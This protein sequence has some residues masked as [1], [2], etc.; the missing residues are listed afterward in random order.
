MGSNLLRG[1]STRAVR[2]PAN[3]ALYWA[4][5]GLVALLFALKLH[6]LFLQNINWDEFVYLAMVHAAARGELSSVLQTGYV[7]VFAWLPHVSNSEVDQVIAARGVM[8][9]LQAATCGFIYLVGRRLFVSATAAFAGVLVYLT[10]SFVVEH[11]TSFRADP[12]AIF[13]L[14][15]ALWLIVR[16]RGGMTEI[17][18]AGIL[19]GLAGMVTIKSAFYVPTL[20][21]AVLCLRGHAGARQRIGE[22]LALGITA[23]ATFLALYLAHRYSLDGATGYSA[24]DMVSR[25]TGKLIMVDE[26]FPRDL[27]IGHSIL[28]DALAWL[29][30]L[31]GFAI[32]IGV[33]LTRGTRRHGI[34]LAGL[35]LPLLTLVF[36]RNAFPYYFVFMLAAPA[37]LVA[38]LVAYAEDRLLAAKR[39]YFRVLVGVLVV[40]LTGGMVERYLNDNVDRTIVQRQVVDTVHRM[41]PEPVPYIDRCSMIASFPKA[42]FFMSTWGLQNYLEIGRPVM[43]DLLLERKPVFLIGNII[44]LI[45][46]LQEDTYSN[47]LL[48]EDLTVLREN[49]LRHWG[50]IWVAG[51]KLDVGA[52]GSE[53]RFEILIPGTYTLDGEAPVVIDGVERAPGDRVELEQ[54]EHTIYSRQAPISV[55][56]RWGVDLYRPDFLPEPEPVFVS[57]S[58]MR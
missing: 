6:L 50:L 48:P 1:P 3:P 58:G 8:F 30:L 39:I 7:H 33:A 31:I 38:G 24:T 4:L 15:A 28:H 12:I 42:G 34:G 5:A 16:D 21:L 29:L 43:R 20:G 9:V 54:G 44:S 35:G 27:Y 26:F 32:A 51:K 18:V 57:F 14:M 47:P 56:L 55:K 41:F 17:A 37:V 2:I 10:F 49:F 45:L 40:F 22:F 13:L 36:Y 19:T 23:L 46:Y 53:S 25:S 11:G 52:A